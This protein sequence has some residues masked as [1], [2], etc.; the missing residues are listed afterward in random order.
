MKLVLRSM[1]GSLFVITII[2]P[3]FSPKIL[4]QSLTKKNLG[5]AHD[6]LLPNDKQATLDVVRNDDVIKIRI[7]LL[8]TPFKLIA[9]KGLVG[10]QGFVSVPEIGKRHSLLAQINK[11][12]QFFL[13]DYRVETTP[14]KLLR[15]S[16]LYSVKLDLYRL[17]GE[18]GQLEEFLGTFTAHGK[19]E[20]SKPNLYILSGV[21]KFQF[22]DSSGKLL[23]ELMAGRPL[24]IQTTSP[25][26]SRLEK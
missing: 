21:S 6:L 18:Y 13:G 2:L 4:A 17:F 20:L 5:D 11:P 14:I 8:V 12:N 9:S 23:V 7:P 19:M 16:Q 3:G 24:E 26:I 25:A 1:I 10:E 22:R 15:A